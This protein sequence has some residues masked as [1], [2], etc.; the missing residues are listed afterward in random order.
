MSY[1]NHFLIP[2]TRALKNLA[3]AA[4]TV[5][6]AETATD[7]KPF[8]AQKFP[9][10]RHHHLDLTRN[11]LGPTKDNFCQNLDF[12][13]FAVACYTVLMSRNIE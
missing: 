12:R 6:K 11:L 7:A 2:P 3:I 9:A 10:H 5:T 8:L 13:Y 4:T 1:L